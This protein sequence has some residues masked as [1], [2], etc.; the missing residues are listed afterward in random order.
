M[1]NKSVVFCRIWYYLIKVRFRI[2]VLIYYCGEHEL[3]IDVVLV[4]A[5]SGAEPNEVVNIIL[6]PRGSKFTL[7][8]ITSPYQ[9]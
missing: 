3:P 9:L 6:R 5:T 8:R 4:T 2:A 1:N 7:K